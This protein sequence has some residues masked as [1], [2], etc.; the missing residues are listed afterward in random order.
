MFLDTGRLGEPKQGARKKLGLEQLPAS[1]GDV[2][3]RMMACEI[4]SKECE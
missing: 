4:D 2:V 1:G 3:A